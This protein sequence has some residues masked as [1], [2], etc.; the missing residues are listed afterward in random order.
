M[1]SPETIKPQHAGA[2]FI[3]ERIAEIAH[4]LPELEHLSRE[5]A[6]RT[7]RLAVVDELK[8]QVRRRAAA[9]RLDWKVQRAIFISDKSSAR[10]RAVYERS[11]TTG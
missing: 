6:T 1:S 2:A 11:L 8:D 5:D 9:E 10:T 7:M 3:A 4:E